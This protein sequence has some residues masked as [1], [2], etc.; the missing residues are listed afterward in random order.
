MTCV[1]ADLNGTKPAPGPAPKKGLCS[2]GCLFNVVAD[3]TEQSNVYASNPDIVAKLTG[4]LNAFK[5]GFFQNH[6][7]FTNDC[8]SGTK[9][10]ACWMAKSRY[11][12]FMGP[13]A[14]LSGGGRAPF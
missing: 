9:N 4:E 7:K 10:C 5:S 11:G 2:N 13:Y 1:T 8:P 3:P 12:G 6:D 14:L